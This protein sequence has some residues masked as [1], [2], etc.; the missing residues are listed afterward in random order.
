[1]QTLDAPGAPQ[2]ENRPTLTQQEFRLILKI[3]FLAVLTRIVSV[4][5]I[6]F[7]ILK[8]K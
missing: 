6:V 5:E 2:T 8:K 7:V 3:P 1:M 4:F